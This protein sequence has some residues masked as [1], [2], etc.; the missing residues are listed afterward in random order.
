MLC[1]VR[2]VTIIDN[3]NN[4]HN[5]FTKI[6]NNNQHKNAKCHFNVMIIFTNIGLHVISGY[7]SLKNFLDNMN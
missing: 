7:E 6:S 5:L 3:K 2:S 4:P 1:N